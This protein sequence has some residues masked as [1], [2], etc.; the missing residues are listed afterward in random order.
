MKRNIVFLTLTKVA[1]L[2][3]ALALAMSLPAI[4]RAAT[5]TWG[6]DGTGGSATWDSGSTPNWFD[7]ASAVVW[8]ATPSGDDDALFTGTAG[9]VSI[10]SGGAIANDLIFSANGYVIANGTLTLDGSLT[11]PIIQLDTGVNATISS[12]L[13]GTNGFNKLNGPGTLTLTGSNT[14]S[15]SV[16]LGPISGGMLSFGYLKITQASA[17]G[18]IT[19]LSTRSSGTRLVLDG[20]GGDI[21]LSSALKFQIGYYAIESVTGNNTI[22]GNI[23]CFN[24]AGTAGMQSDAGTLTLAGNVSSGDSGAINLGLQ[25]ASTQANTISGVISDGSSTVSPIKYGSGTWVLA[26]ANTYSGTTTLG[27]YGAGP[28]TVNDGTLRLANSSALGTGILA[29]RGNYQIG[30][31]ELAGNITVTN[32]VSLDS[33]Q[34]AT[35]GPAIRNLSGTN[36]LGGI[37]TGGIGGASYNIGSDGGLLIIS[38]KFTTAGTSGTKFLNLRGTANGAIPGVIENGVA[39]VG[40]RMQG[41]GVWVLSGANTYTG[42]NTITSGQLQFANEVSLYNNNHASWTAANLIVSANAVAAFNV[43]GPGEFTSSDIATL[44]ALGT[45][46]AGFLTGAILGLDTSD[47]VGGFAFGSNLANPNAGANKLGL[48]KFGANQLTLSGANTYTGPTTISQGILSV[49]GSLGNTALTN[50]GGTLTGNGIINGPVVIASGTLAPGVSTSLSETLTINN[51]LTLAG[52][53]LIQIGKA[54]AT[55]VNDSVVGVTNITYGGTLIL[56]NA[57]GA[58]FVAGDAFVL[59]TA[60]GTKTANF[61]NIVV[62]PPVAGLNTTFDPATGTLTFSST[63]VATPT[64]N[65][66]NNGGGALQFGWTGSF[67]LQSQTNAVSTG[68]STNWVDYPGGATSPVNVTVDPTLGSVFFRLSQ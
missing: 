26:G 53:A 1:R 10:A 31:V 60:S 8:P 32:N 18:A 65:F 63:V 55:P 16:S 45:A 27:N 40:P 4:T 51:N 7:G 58:S 20:S 57:T 48:R 34:Q 33:R 54:R 47:A 3:L 30:I 5:L 42:P 37:L 61:T 66:T 12:V 38:N 56:T 29:I 39:V 14:I 9:T 64:L 35:Y 25:G 28:S 13:D 2:G 15:G 62:Q 6:A 23:D 59:F 11:V 52:T 68:L 24:A 50:N 44:A 19:N 17:L 67:K 36:T 41:S 21:S 46:S 49:S 22:N 43:G